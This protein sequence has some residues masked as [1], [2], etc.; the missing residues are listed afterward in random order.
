MKKILSLL[1]YVQ[2]FFQNY[3]SIH[4]GLSQN[5]ILAYRDALKLF[6]ESVSSNKK[7]TV[8]RL[9]ME[10][11]SSDAVLTFLKEIESTR[12]NSVITRN[13]RLAA[14]KTFFG[15]MIGRDTLRVGQY[16]RIIAIPFKRTPKP[17]MGYLEVNEVKA[18]LNNIDRTAK[19]GE[20]D[21]V[22]LNLLY[23]TG[24]R[25]QEACDL[26][27]KDIQLHHPPFV[28]ITGKGRKTRQVPLWPETIRLLESY[29]TNRSIINNPEAKLFLNAYGQELGRFGIR[30]IIKKRI[31]NVI[32]QCPTL[33]TKKIGPHTFRHTTAMHLLQAGIDLTIIKNWLGHVSLETTHAYLEV[34]LEMKR[35]ALS[36]CKP[37]QKSND[38]RKILE[39]NRDVISWLE[40]V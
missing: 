36:L 5:T 11:L 15:Y 19:N 6:L 23:N 33:A 34:N 27:V 37:A 29:L 28:T 20:R 8:T 14:L 3:L 31:A 1:E 21:Y 40:S 16:Q 9:T 18:I 24:M 30:Y 38:L 22:L 35:K 39:Q 13:L 25:V 2:D 7:Q 4:R 32:A 17:L 26:R 12:N 10:D